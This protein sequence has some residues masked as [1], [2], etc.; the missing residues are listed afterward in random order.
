MKSGGVSG[1]EGFIDL[2]EGGVN[3][4]SIPLNTLPLTHRDESGLRFHPN[5][6]PLFCDEQYLVKKIGSQ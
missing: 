3:R 4:L 1:V 2:K 5:L 6:A